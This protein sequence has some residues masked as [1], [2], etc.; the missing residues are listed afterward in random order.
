MKRKPVL[1]LCLKG[2]DYKR[3]VGKNNTNHIITDAPLVK[4]WVE[5]FRINPQS[6]SDSAPVTAA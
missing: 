2:N 5:Q 1:V 4:Y 3:Y 6:L